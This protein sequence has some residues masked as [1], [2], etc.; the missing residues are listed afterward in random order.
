M[1]KYKAELYRPSDTERVKKAAVRR[2]VGSEPYRTEYRRDQARLLHSAAFRRLQGKTQLYPGPESDFFRNRLTHSLEVAQIAKSIAIRLNDLVPFF[3]RSPIAPELVELA[4]LLHDLGHPP[5]GHNGEKALDDC[6]KPYGGFEGNAQT[7]RII[8]RLERKEVVGP[9][10]SS[11]IDENGRDNRIG[12]NFTYRSI[13]SALKYDHEIDPTR[14]ATASL[15]KGY[16]HSDA[17]IVGAVKKAV[18]PSLPEGKKFKTIECSI[19]DLADDI[20]YSTYDL[21]SAVF[22]DLQTWRHDSGLVREVLKDLHFAQ[23][24]GFQV[25]LAQ[26]RTLVVNVDGHTCYE[27]AN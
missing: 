23:R 5:F 8:T 16:Y 7:L 10:S 3:Q 14:D 27:L 18:A 20:A 11:G 24:S 4:G 17:K 1:R 12:L 19:M 25:R 21:V 13:A 26:W 6:M 9:L 22:G 15:S 2:G